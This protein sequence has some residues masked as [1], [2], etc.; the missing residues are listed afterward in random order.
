MISLLALNMSEKK[1]LIAFQKYNFTNL[2]PAFFNP[3]PIKIADLDKYQS[4]IPN[5]MRDYLEVPRFTETWPFFSS[6]ETISKLGFK[7]S[8]NLLKEECP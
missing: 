8:K 4:I 5:V 2:V 7:A 1:N 6:F 3:F